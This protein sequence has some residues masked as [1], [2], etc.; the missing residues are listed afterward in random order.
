VSSGRVTLVGRS[1]EKLASAAARLRRSVATACFD[2]GDAD[3]ANAG[4]I[5][6]VTF[7]QFVSTAAT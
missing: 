4:F 5:E 6:I 2:L 3:A 1:S 7:D